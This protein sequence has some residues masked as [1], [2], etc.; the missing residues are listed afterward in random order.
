M[1]ING[2]QTA[3]YTR[4]IASLVLSELGAIENTGYTVVGI[5]TTTADD[6]D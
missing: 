6:T 4:I 1:T 2:T 3:K 5:I